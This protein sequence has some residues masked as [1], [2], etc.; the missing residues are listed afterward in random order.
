M[1]SLLR[2]RA[3]GFLIEDAKK[4]SEIEKYRDE[5]RLYQLLLPV[6]RVF[7]GL[8]ALHVKRDAMRLL[9]NGNPLLAE[10]TDISEKEYMEL[11]DGQRFRV[12]N[13]ENIFCGIYIYTER[14]KKLK[15]E[16]MFYVPA[17]EQRQ[18]RSNG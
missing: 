12:Y 18:N 14:E 10:Q 11:T 2:T 5:N 15:P 4:L 9:D 8:T 7:D 17:A 3:S 1:E 16:K 13:A 6:D